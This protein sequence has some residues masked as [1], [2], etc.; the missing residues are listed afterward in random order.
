MNEERG[1]LMRIQE[2]GPRRNASSA[3]QSRGKK[4]WSAIQSNVSGDSID[5][6]TH[7]ESTGQKEAMKYLKESCYH[8]IESSAAN[9]LVTLMWKWYLNSNFQPYSYSWKFQEVADGIR[10]KASNLVY[11]WRVEM[12]EGGYYKKERRPWGRGIG[13]WREKHC[14]DRN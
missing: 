10:I 3:K 7:H 1:L 11:T 5:K 2:S 14:N 4:V 8:R 6:D 13:G 9:S 12:K